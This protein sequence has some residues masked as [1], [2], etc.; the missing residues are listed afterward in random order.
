M[1]KTAQDYFDA[2]SSIFLHDEWEI[3]MRIDIV[4]GMNAFGAT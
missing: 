4:V 3:N 2:V 1:K